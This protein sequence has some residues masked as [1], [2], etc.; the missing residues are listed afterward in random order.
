MVETSF[1][2]ATNNNSKSN[3]IG[4]GFQNI[5]HSHHS[6]QNYR[7]DRQRQRLSSSPSTANQWEY[8]EITLNRGPNGLGFTVAGG[9]DNPHYKNDNSIY[10]TRLVPN[11]LAQVDGR[12]KLEDIIVRVDDVDLIDVTHAEAVDSLKNSKN[13]VQLLIK[14][15]KSATT[16]EEVD[17]NGCNETSN[18]KNNNIASLINKYQQVSQASLISNKS[19]ST[20]YPSQKNTPALSSNQNLPPLPSSSNFY[21]IK[22]PFINNSLKLQNNQDRKIKDAS[23]ALSLHHD[24]SSGSNDPDASNGSSHF[25]DR[26]NVD[27]KSSPA[28]NTDASKNITRSQRTVILHRTEKGLGFNIVGGAEGGGTFITYIVP[29][30]SAERSK[31]LYCGDQIMSVNGIDLRFATHEEAAKALKQSGQ[32]VKLIVKYR[33]EE[34]VKFENRINEVRERNIVYSGTLKT[35]QKRSLY[36]RALFDYDPSKDSGL[37]SKGLAF[38]FGDIL[39]ITNASDDDWWQARKV[40]D[41]GQDDIVNGIIPSSKKLE[42]RERTRLKSVK[43]TGR[44][45][46]ETTLDRRRKKISFSRRF[47]FMKSRKNFGADFDDPTLVGSQS[48]S[49][50]ILSTSSTMSINNPNS[51]RGSI[52]NESEELVLSYEPVLLHEINYKRPVALY[53]LKDEVEGLRGDLAC[54]T[55][56]PFYKMELIVPYTSRAKRDGEVD[57]VKYHFVSRQRME[58]DLADHKFVEAGKLHDNLYGT[59]IESIR[60]VAETGKHCL[61]NVKPNAIKLLQEAGIH[62]IVILTKPKSIEVLLEMY[63]RWSYEDAANA[64]DYCQRL[65]QDYGSYFTA[66]V[67]IENPSGPEV[68]NK[69]IK[70]IEQQST[71]RIW[72]RTTYE[73]AT[74]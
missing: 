18:G 35:S 39:H 71:P 70:I 3:V 24:L 53:G 63:K 1:R 32:T 2:S 68:Y 26:E 10:I 42:K 55:R 9:V 4:D 67:T 25:Y 72:I 43:F 74:G 20:F 66:T 44:N 28:I 50:G 54:D 30:G 60:E 64:M 27:S 46:S 56:F 41:N 13:R 12:L 69:I 8:E 14:R 11:G 34:Y 61:L 21:S 22:E 23:S 29:G 17:S 40:L 38:K 62:P 58:K 45:N 49:R 48:N 33:P 6:D 36:A 65:E 47:P 7:Y 15:R 19:A 37:P 52:R 5:P 73:N 31:K 59:S 16:N 51:E 57:G